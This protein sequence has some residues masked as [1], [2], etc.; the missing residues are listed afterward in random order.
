MRRN[1]MLVLLF[2]FGLFVLYTVL[3]SATGEH[4]PSIPTALTTLTGF[5]FGLLHA[6]ERLGWSMAPIITP[7]N[8]VPNSWVLCLISLR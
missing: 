3:N 8:S 6:S 2:L 4:W 7:K 5:G 1:L